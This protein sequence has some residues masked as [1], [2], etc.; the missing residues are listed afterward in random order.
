MKRRIRISKS[1]LP[2]SYKQKRNVKKPSKAKII[3]KK[4]ISNQIP[5]QNII[6]RH[7]KIGLR[8]NKKILK[9]ISSKKNQSSN[10]F[11]VFIF[12]AKSAIKK[13]FKQFISEKKDNKVKEKKIIFPIFRSVL[14]PLLISCKFYYAEIHI[15]CWTWVH[16]HIIDPI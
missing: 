12:Q 14:W 8:D 2:I 7:Q 9:K 11:S 4:E 15:V 13:K 10:K 16:S 3:F 5:L 1:S 6:L